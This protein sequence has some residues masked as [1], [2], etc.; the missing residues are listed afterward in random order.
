MNRINGQPYSNYGFELSKIEGV[1]DMPSRL[2]DVFYDWGDYFEPLVHE[3]DIFWKERDIKI[4]VFFDGN[5]YG[6]PLS[7]CLNL[8]KGLPE[9]FALET[10]YGMFNVK[11]KQVIKTKG[12]TEKFAKLKLIFNENIPSFITDSIGIPTG[13]DGATIDNFNFFNDL[14]IIVSEAKFIEDI[15]ILKQSNITVFNTSKPFTENR[16]L[17]TVLFSCSIPYSIP[18]ELRET[19][20]KIKKILSQEGTREVYYKGRGYSCFLSEGF[21]VKFYG[22]GLVKLNIKLNIATNFIELGFVESGFITGG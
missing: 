21:N 5:R 8:L 17:R 20:D 9:V 4:D 19:T 6:M 22:R 10:K 16:T 7:E 18:L 11:L 13:G 3:K 14:G 12:F 15:P 1:L 2:G